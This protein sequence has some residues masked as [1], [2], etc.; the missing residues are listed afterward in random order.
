MT[1]F[2]ALLRKELA[3]LF[4]T[5]G[6]YLVLTG[7]SLVS[8]L[9]FFEHLQVYNQVLFVYASST[10]GGFETDTLPDYVNL[11]DSVFFPVAETL[12]VTLL[13]A[14][15]LVTMRVFA[16][17]RA[18]GTDTLLFA[19]RLTGGRIVV[20]K[21]VV[22]FVLVTGMLAASF[23]YP[24]AAI[25]RGGIG[26]EHLFSVFL[27]LWLHGLAVAAIGLA[28]SAFASHQWVAAIAAWTAAFVF[29]DFGWATPFVNE[30]LAA[31]LRQLSL[32]EHVGTLAE[33]VVAAT[34][35]AYFAGVILVGLAL[36]RFAW[37]LRRVGA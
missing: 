8:A 9:I 2:L 20:A 32:R 37:D 12:A 3:C 24:A 4:G 15:P 18:R 16:E 14:I 36:A 13:A 10:M 11:W 27:G 19:T 29:W 6:V 28:C 7:V 33:G 26:A 30:G 23:L 34:D 1:P 21:F 31:S 5:S 35:L 17:E 25:E 22:T